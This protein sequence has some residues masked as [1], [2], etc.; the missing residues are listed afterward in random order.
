MVA[1]QPLTIACS[2]VSAKRA[3][4]SYAPVLG[5]ARS[6]EALLHLVTLLSAFMHCFD[7]YSLVMN[8]SCQPDGHVGLTWIQRSWWVENPIKLLWSSHI[9]LALHA[10]RWHKS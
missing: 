2:A 1:P 7:R 10:G 9:V 4:C 6:R 3:C 8:S 5:G